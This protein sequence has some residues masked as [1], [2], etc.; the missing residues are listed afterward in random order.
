MKSLL[1]AL[2]I[3]GPSL[4]PAQKSETAVTAPSQPAVHV[5]S[6]FTFNLNAPLQQAAPPLRARRRTRVGR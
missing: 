4:L 3:C 5:S 6:S 2:A 1:L